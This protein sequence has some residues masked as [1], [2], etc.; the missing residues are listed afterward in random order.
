MK[1]DVNTSI[2]SQELENNRRHESSEGNDRGW[3]KSKATNSPLNLLGKGRA[4]SVFGR[5]FNDLYKFYVAEYGEQ[6]VANETKRSQLMSLILL[7]ISQEKLIERLAQDEGDKLAS[8]THS[9]IHVS[10]Q[11]EKVLRNLAILT[12][13][14]PKE[15]KEALALKDTVR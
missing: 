6:I 7:T 4:N 15:A 14:K 10:A 8:N 5:R 11:I 3:T 1:F 9:L 2:V 12:G 13:K